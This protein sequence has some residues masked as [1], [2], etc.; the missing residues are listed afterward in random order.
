MT[1]IGGCFVWTELGPD[2][3]EITDYH[4]GQR[5]IR[6]PSHRAPPHPG[7]LLREE[8][9]VPLGLTQRSLAA[10]ISLPYQRVNELVNG[11]RSVTAPTALRLARYLGT[12]PEMWLNLQ[13]R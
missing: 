13:E 9:L 1:S 12:S 10:A 11:R 2:R 4:L 8:F 5:M 3:A 6:G 7:V